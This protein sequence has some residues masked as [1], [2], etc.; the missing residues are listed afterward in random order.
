MS[1]SIWHWAQV[2]HSGTARHV[3][4]FETSCVELS[5]SQRAPHASHLGGHIEMQGSLFD[6]VS[7]TGSAL[8]DQDPHFVG[9]CCFTVIAVDGVVATRSNAT[10]FKISCMATSRW[11]TTLSVLGGCV[12]M[13]TFRLASQ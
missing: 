10:S 5:G 4:H 6:Q 9:S 7:L 2:S 12:S 3:L 11:N 1:I 13:I 8:F